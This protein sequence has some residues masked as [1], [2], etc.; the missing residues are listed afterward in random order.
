MMLYKLL[1]RMDRRRLSAEV[2]SLIGGGDVRRMIEPLDIP[3][4][5]LDMTTAIARTPSALWRLRA[6]LAA[7]PDSIVQTWM[8]HADLLAGLAARATGRRPV[9]WGIQGSPL[10]PRTT[11]RTTRWTVR[12]CARLSRRLPARIVC[13]GPATARAHIALGYDE[14]RMVVIPNG[15]DADLFVPSQ[16]A[17]RAVRAELGLAPTALLV[18]MPARFHPQKDHRTL[19]EALGR[20]AAGHDLRPEVLLFGLDIT[21]DNLDLRDAIQHAGV[22]RHVH[23]LGRRQDVPR[24]LAAC[25]LSV[26]SSAYGEGLP[27]ALVEAM[28]CGV[29]CVTT[30]VGDSRW[31]VGAT[32]EVVPPRAPVELAE[33]MARMLTLSVETRERL[34]RAARE[35]VLSDFEIGAIALRYEALYAAVGGAA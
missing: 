18:G 35:R 27:N 29:P 30:D 14:G 26:L 28:A 8:F 24:L 33:A 32:G 16:E 22:V 12:A 23:L 25:D 15:A 20:L 21:P 6:R 2:I 7:R 19:I 34:G 5:S 31:V 3:V 10:D 9:I 17:R 13:C 11:P 4:T 1:A